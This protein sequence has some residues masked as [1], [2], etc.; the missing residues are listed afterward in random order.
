MEF[1]KLERK[2]KVA[3]LTISRADKLNALNAQ[4]LDELEQAVDEL[5]ADPEVVAVVITGEGK[6]FVA[7]ADIG[8][9]K[10]LSK[11]EY[12]QKMRRGQRLMDKI[13]QSPKVFIAAVNGYALGGGLELALA[14]DIRLASEKAKVGLPEVGLGL[15]PGYGGTQRLPRAAGVG[16]ASYVIL[17]GR[18]LTAEEAL[19]AGIVQGV[20]PAESLL[21]EALKL[22]EEIA[23]KAPLALAAAKRSIRNSYSIPPDAG[24]EEEARLFADV[25]ST[26]DAQEGLSAFLEKRAPQFKGR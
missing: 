8:E 7:G 6:A 15:I 4:V 5:S 20:Y 18:M 26:E 14:C 22:A 11:E 1:V 24:F 2:G 21:D 13:A 19:R 12:Y 10:G 3:L 9:L 17:S 16:W 25:A 23:S